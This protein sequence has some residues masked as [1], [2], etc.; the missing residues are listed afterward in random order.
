M[1]GRKCTVTVG[2]RPPAWQARFFGEMAEIGGFFCEPA[3]SCS[4]RQ[5]KKGKKYGLKRSILGSADYLNQ[6][7][8]A[9]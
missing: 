5:A 6:P 4:T 8:H 1:P 9:I 3:G 7:A 2:Q